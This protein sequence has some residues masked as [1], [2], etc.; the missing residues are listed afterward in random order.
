MPKKNEK[1]IDESWFVLSPS[2]RQSSLEVKT[3][4]FM[5]KENDKTNDESRF[6]L[7]PSKQP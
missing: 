1:R 3:T 5:L 2:I 7:S 6:V 4:L